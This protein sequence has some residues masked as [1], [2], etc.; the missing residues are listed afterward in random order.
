MER[1]NKRMMRKR[2][3][4]AV[5]S[6]VLLLTAAA[7]SKEEQ[8]MP[9][10]EG[11][12]G[13]AGEEDGV[14]ALHTDEAELVMEN[15]KIRLVLDAQTGGIVEL[16]NKQSGL[17]LTKDAEAAVPLRLQTAT[18]NI[19]SYESFA[20][21]VRKD[22]AQEK[23]L[24]LEWGVQG[25]LRIKAQ[26]SLAE[27]ADEVDFRLS[28]QGNDPESSIISVE[29]PI[30]EDI[31]TLSDPETDYFV[32]PF[33]TGMLFHNPVESFNSDF[34]GITKELGRYPSGWEYPMQFSGY[35]S[36]DK[37]G[38]YWQTKDAKDTVKSFTM[39]GNDGGLRLSI[40]HFLDDTS[41]V[42]VDFDYD[43]CFANMTR[44]TWYEAAD[45]YR[46][47]AS[48][49]PWAVE[50][51]RLAER[52]DVDRELYEDT[53]LTIFGYRVTED[54]ADYPDIYD[55]L[56]NRIDGKFLNVA[57][58]R[59]NTY[60]DKIDQYGDLIDCFEFSSLCLTDSAEQYRD[61][62]SS[63]M[64]SPTGEKETFTIHYYE[65]ASDEAWREYMMTREEGFIR[66]YN[67]DGFYYDVDIAADHP[68]Q[69]YDTTHA[70]GTRVNVIQD[71]LDQI[72]DAK[73]LKNPQK[74]DKALSVGTE[75]IFEQM[76][77]YVNYYQARA[78]SGVLG[79][80]EHDR[81]RSVME[82]GSGSLIPLFDYVYHEY[83]V[84]RTDGYLIP[85]EK[86]GDGFYHVAAYVVLNGGI[87]EFNY[88]FYNAK[89][90]PTGQEQYLPYIDFVNALG[91]VRTG[92][93]RDFLVYG[94]MMPA[95]RV[96]GGTSQYEF[97]NANYTPF[98]CL[99]YDVLSGTAE[100]DRI[101]TSAYAYEGQTA[102]FLCNVS[103]ETQSVS[104]TLQA[105]ADYGVTSG[106]ITGHTGEE[107]FDAGS[108]SSGTA[109]ISL[110]LEP[111]QIVML[112]F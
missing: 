25:E 109:D 63:A 85:D 22:D 18:Q 32:S 112:T 105:E 92:F 103:G 31:G 77:P 91:Q 80:M 39:T 83:G 16:Y 88:E 23:Q 62:F 51:G 70:H 17:Y 37:G 1:R 107:T 76:L 3:A 5:V 60:L 94:K 104:F 47:W 15:G 53:V 108:I 86:L 11:P 26:V 58:Y 7:C 12:V 99:G 78:G 36:Q 56:K 106:K 59:N 28:L 54:W 33:I 68:K 8:N 97:S 74:P 42:D 89:E 90:L 38:F 24:A 72:A 4:A 73:K 95:P 52:T 61:F 43:I 98:Q 75:M 41:A 44:G 102:V 67:V 55:I 49:Q 9:E 96:E 34:Y 93:G 20:Y 35:Y 66:N 29:Y 84:L 45:R 21:E 69:C 82:N 64:M 71:F 81:V 100:L 10:T 101:V 40:Y 14:L 87:P 57:I 111:R 50:T 2:A 27:T 13:N 110:E 48:E 6:L 30:I 65:C 46:D 79:W 19:S